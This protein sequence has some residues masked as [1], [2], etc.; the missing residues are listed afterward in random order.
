MLL[1]LGLADEARALAPAIDVDEPE[2]WFSLLVWCTAGEVALGIGDAQLGA[3]AYARAAPYS[4]GLCLGGTGAPLG[5][6]DAFL[7]LAA[8][9]TGETATAGRHA[10]LALA[11]CQ[12]WQ[13]PPVAQWLR[14]Q[15]D[16]YGF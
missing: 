14:D 4:G 15:R 16:R 2:S 5:P 7:A 9:A 1:R 3:A 13:I 10:D 6:V 8:A 11:Q 12:E